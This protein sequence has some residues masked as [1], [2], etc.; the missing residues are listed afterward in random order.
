MKAKSLDTANAVGML[1]GITRRTLA[2]NHEL[3]LCHFTLE[4]G[5]QI[6]LHQHRPSQIGFVLSGKVRFKGNTDEDN[7]EVGPGESYVIDP[8]VVHGGEAVE[9]TVFIEVFS[10]SRPEYDD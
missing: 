8:E 5:A 9:D 6:P 10:T 2:R 7:F 1:P 4:K 3:M